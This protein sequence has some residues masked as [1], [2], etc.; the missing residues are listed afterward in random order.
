MPL[1][2]STVI[3]LVSDG[4]NGNSNFRMFIVLSD[5]H[6]F[7]SSSNFTH[8]ITPLRTYTKNAK[9]NEGKTASRLQHM[10]FMV[11]EIISARLRPFSAMAM[12]VISAGAGL[13]HRRPSVQLAAKLNVHLSA[14]DNYHSPEWWRQNDA[15]RRSAS[16]CTISC[17]RLWSSASKDAACG[18]WVDGPAR[19]SFENAR[20]HNA[21]TVHGKARISAQSVTPS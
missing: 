1:S 17:V 11:R 15:Y 19:K 10:A 16:P 21:S 5:R 6:H 9:K 3:D 13:H 18:G 8:Q 4:A 7:F 2:I 12:A 14:P 20:T